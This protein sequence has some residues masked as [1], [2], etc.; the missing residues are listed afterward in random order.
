MPA[1]KDPR[2]QNHKAEKRK[3]WSTPQLRL[4]GNA[5]SARPSCNKQETRPLSQELRFSW[6]N[7]ADED[8]KRRAA[9]QWLDTHLDR[10]TAN[11]PGEPNH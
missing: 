10:L 7:L 6:A 8:E 1:L 4:L 9:R 2:P 3:K 11:R 5:V